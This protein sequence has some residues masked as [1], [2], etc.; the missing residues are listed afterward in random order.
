MINFLSIRVGDYLRI[1]FTRPYGYALVWYADR[2]LE[3]RR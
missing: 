3:D 2:A 1:G